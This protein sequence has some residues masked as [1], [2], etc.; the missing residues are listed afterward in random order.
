MDQV[1]VYKEQDNL[2]ET[3]RRG[4]HT[5]LPTVYDEVYQKSVEREESVCGTESDVWDAYEFP[6]DTTHTSWWH[7]IPLWIKVLT[8]FLI[9]GITAS[10][11]DY[12]AVELTKGTTEKRVTTAQIALPITN[13]TDPS[14]GSCKKRLK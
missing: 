8:L 6:R 3:L 1:S 11:F 12:L 5:P 10:Y 4:K 14:T 2:Y 7:C 9:I 13:L